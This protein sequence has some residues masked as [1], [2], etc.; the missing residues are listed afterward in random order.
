MELDFYEIYKSFSTTELL[1]IV[2]R[3]DGFQPEAVEAAR[4]HLSE[5]DIAP[6]DQVAVRTFYEEKDRIAMAKA[7]KIDRLKEQAADLLLPV[8]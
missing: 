1:K 2:H 6:E 5:R 3:P 7:E 8:I 4:R